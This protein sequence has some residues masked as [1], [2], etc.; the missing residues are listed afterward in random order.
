MGYFAYE[1]SG[2]IE[3][4]V[5]RAK[6]TEKTLRYHVLFLS[7]ELEQALPFSQFP[8]LRVEGEIADCQVKL[9]WQPSGSR[10]HY[11]LLSPAI[12][13]QLGLQVGDEITLRFNLAKQDEVELPDA[14]QA[15][16]AKS[17]ARRKL[18]SAL[19]P[20]R[21]RGLCYFVAS[22]KTEP[23]RIK[24]VASVFDELQR[25]VVERTGP[26]KRQGS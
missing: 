20:G 26:R 3:V 10:G 12:R 2:P 22:A 24:R 18:W 8:R 5:I 19:T 14:L 9:A 6:E 16:L 21:Q 1:T 11:V 15:S 23:T 25:G 13:K 17:A 4:F 7:P